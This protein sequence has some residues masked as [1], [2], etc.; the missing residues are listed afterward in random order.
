MG[1]PWFDQ[2]RRICNRLNQH[3]EVSLCP[4]IPNL[5]LHIGDIVNPCRQVLNRSCNRVA[6]DCRQRLCSKV[7]RDIIWQCAN[8]L[9]RRDRPG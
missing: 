1:F 8:P 9:V 5:L 6:D 2:D 4:S 3:A 7:A